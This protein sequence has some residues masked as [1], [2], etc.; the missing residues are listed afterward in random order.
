MSLTLSTPLL[1]RLQVDP[2]FNTDGSIATASVQAFFSQNLLDDSTS[3]VT[4]TNLG[5]L[6]DGPTLV[7]CVVNATKTV[8]IDGTTLTYN[9]IIRAIAL[10]AAQEKN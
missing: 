9:Q 4:V 1:S 5:Y 2:T 8:V 10:A 7:D 3:P 6:K